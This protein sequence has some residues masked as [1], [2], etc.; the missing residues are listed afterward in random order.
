[1]KERNTHTLSHKI[2]AGPHGSRVARGQSARS[3][4]LKVEGMEVGGLIPSPHLLVLA[5]S[6]RFLLAR[7]TFRIMLVSE[8]HWLQPMLVLPVRWWLAPTGVGRVLIRATSHTHESES[9]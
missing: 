5:T 6:E 8:S 2:R 3:R 9:P 7:G 4:P 1:M